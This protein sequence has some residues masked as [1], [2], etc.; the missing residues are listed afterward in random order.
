MTT[1]Q[2]P[3]FVVKFARAVGSMLLV[4]LLALVGAYTWVHG[5]GNFHEVEKGTV[6]RSAW[7]GSEKLEQAIDR[8]GVKSVL[9]LCGEQPGVE[10]YE[11]EVEVSRRRGIKFVSMGLSANTALDASQ[12]AKLADALRDAPKPLLIH[13]RAGSDRTGLASAIYVATHGGS[14]RDA[15]A[16]LSLYYG[17]FPYF[18]SKSVAMDITLE[19]FYESVS[20]RRVAGQAEVR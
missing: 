10:W 5:G 14:Y 1:P 12:L 2:R 16:Q 9:N 15:Q 13:C 18:G 11:G 7:L 6:Y 4:V 8:L 20:G 19:R 17:H 3:T